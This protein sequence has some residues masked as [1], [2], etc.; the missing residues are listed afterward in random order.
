METNLLLVEIGLDPWTPEHSALLAALPG[1]EQERIGRYRRVAD[2]IRAL[3][4]AILPRVAITR[5]GQRAADQQRALDQIQLPRSK[6][7]KPF[8]AEDPA[9]C[10]NV[11]HSGH[12]VAL[13]LSAAPIGVDCE[14]IQTLRDWHGIAKRFYTAAEQRWLEAAEPD[15]KVNRFYELWSRKESLLKATGDGLS[16]AISEVSVNP[17]GQ[18]PTHIT[19]QGRDWFIRAYQ[20]QPGYSVAL[21]SHSTR[22][23]GAPICVDARSGLL[24]ATTA[25]IAAMTDK[26][27]SP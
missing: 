22:L 27:R 4:A 14:H 15:E 8:Y 23:P 18:E 13:A 10:F 16:G 20:T 12:L 19:F 17:V 3:T 9:F 24:S 5:R 2:R 26:S 11:S 7:G 6:T 1:V 25:V 21:C